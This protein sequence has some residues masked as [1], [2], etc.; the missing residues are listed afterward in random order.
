MAST[1]S[2]VLPVR[3]HWAF[4]S[5][6]VTAA[7]LM[8]LCVTLLSLPLRTLMPGAP[9]LTLLPK[10]RA[11][12][13]SPLPATL[14]AAA[15]TAL[16]ALPS[17]L[18]TLPSFFA[19]DALSSS[20]TLKPPDR[21]TPVALYRLRFSMSL[22]LRLPVV[23]VF[24]PRFT[25]TSDEAMAAPLRSVLPWTRTVKPSSPASRRDCSTTL[26]KSPSTLLLA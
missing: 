13:A 12:Q 9:A 14:L 25:A 11:D 19:A 15:S 17:S 23:T 22:T 18:P 3:S 10:F 7:P 2:A 5:V 8:P 20:A 6:M 26:A 21:L 16:L 1:C 4:M 24:T